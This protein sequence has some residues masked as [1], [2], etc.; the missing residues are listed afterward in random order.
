MF[1][2]VGHTLPFVNF[3]LSRELSQSGCHQGSYMMCAMDVHVTQS[4]LHSGKS[5]STHSHWLLPSEN[6]GRKMHLSFWCS[7]WMLGT[8]PAC[9]G[10][11]LG[12]P[13]AMGYLEA[14]GDL[15]SS[16]KVAQSV[17][18]AL[19]DLVKVEELGRVGETTLHRPTIVAVVRGACRLP[20][21]WLCKLHWRFS[22]WCWIAPQTSQVTK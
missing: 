10:Q 11:A 8:H 20:R 15:R 13:W 7:T 4:L 14:P 6:S 12:P 3:M 22:C 19:E 1:D 17:N 16:I 21:P 5:P 9:Q 18:K 2:T